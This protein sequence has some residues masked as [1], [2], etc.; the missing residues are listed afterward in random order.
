MKKF[1]ITI[2]ALLLSVSSLLYGAIPDKACK[3]AAYSKR[4]TNYRNAESIYNQDM[5]HCYDLVN[6][7]HY[8][9]LGVCLNAASNKFNEAKKDADLELSL[10]L[11]ACSPVNF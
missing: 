6:E 4:D 7:G 8:I 1:Q 9:I 2:I 5:M 10:D 11:S 3:D